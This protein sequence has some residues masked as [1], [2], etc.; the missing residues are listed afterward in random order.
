MAYLCEMKEQAP[1]PTLVIR[2]CTSVEELPQVLG[3]AYG[4]I[5]Q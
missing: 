1:Q 5:A 3:Q 2:T 4:A